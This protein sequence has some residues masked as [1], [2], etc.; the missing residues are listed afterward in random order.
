MFSKVLIANRGEIAVRIT[1]SL[2]ELGITAVAVFSDPDAASPHV[3]CA[4]EA[5]PLDGKTAA[6]TYLRSEKILDIAVAHGVDA[7]HP[8]Y[9]F[10]SENSE[11]AEACERAGVT[12]IGPKPDVIRSMGDKTL[13]K[14]AMQDAG[15]PVVPGWPCPA[16]A[17][18]EDVQAAADKIGYP[19][20]C[21]AAAG[22]GGK[23]MR[24]VASSGELAEAWQAAGREA[25]AAFGDGRVF[26]EKYIQR[27][28]HVEFQI[29]GDDAGNVVHLFDRECSIQRRYQKVI[30]ESPSPALDDTLRRE[31]GE[32]AVRAGRAIGYTNAGTVEFILG[33]NGE[34]YFLEVNTR[35]QVEHP[36]TEMVTGRDLVRAQLIVAA[37]GELPFSQ[38]DLSQTG[39]AVE[40]RIYAEDASRGFLPS[41]GKI[42][43]Y[44]PPAGPNIRVDS[45]VAER[46][47]VSVFYDPMLSKLIVWGRDRTEALSRMRWALDHYVVLG[48]TTNISLLRDIIEHPEFQA[49]RIHTHFLADHSFDRQPEASAPLEALVAAAHVRS[50]SPNDGRRGATELTASNASPWHQAGPWRGL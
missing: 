23:G 10:L 44:L 32:S 26:L 8:G 1:Q 15:V 29:F 49:G 39:H 6:E 18:T 35:L 45:G 40:C 30:E 37:G 41:T 21:K 3:A 25:K 33:E 17:G 22:G 16:G 28:R 5:Y 12:F 7:I 50:S 19:L 42:A 4:D 11:F 27:P 31:M 48:V 24:L 20:L 43:R 46:N 14:Q 38:A 13:A 2:Q 34:Y 47:E 9:G 36:V